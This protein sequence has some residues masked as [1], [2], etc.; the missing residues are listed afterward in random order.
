M[1]DGL[2]TKDTFGKDH[3]GTT[4]SAGLLSYSIVRWSGLSGLAPSQ[5]QPVAMVTAGAT[6]FANNVWMKISP[7]LSG[8]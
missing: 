1:S 2:F 7:M 4:A 5:A 3:L 6:F 8:L